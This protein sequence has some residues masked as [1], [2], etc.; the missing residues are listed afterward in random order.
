MILK[1]YSKPATKNLIIFYFIVLLIFLTCTAA[2]IKSLDHTEVNRNEVYIYDYNYNNNP[3]KHHE[4]DTNEV[5]DVK[6]NYVLFVN[7]RCDTMSLSKEIFLY[8]SK[9]IR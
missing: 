9:R 5:L 4:I 2:L 7:Q 8:K 1:T 6:Q 3:F